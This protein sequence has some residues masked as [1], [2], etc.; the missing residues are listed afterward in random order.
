M[1]GFSPMYGGSTGNE[2]NVSE[3]SLVAQI[4]A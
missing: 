2:E 1:L 4:N 3:N